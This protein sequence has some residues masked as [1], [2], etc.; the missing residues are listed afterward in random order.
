MFKARGKNAFYFPRAI[1]DVYIRN[2]YYVLCT[3]KNKNL[4]I[5]KL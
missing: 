3:V 2:T 5:L 1:R 4:N